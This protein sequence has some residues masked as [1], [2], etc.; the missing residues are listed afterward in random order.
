MGKKK[1]PDS[2]AVFWKFRRFFQARSE[3]STAAALE[4]QK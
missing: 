3:L 4:N 1:P 2:P